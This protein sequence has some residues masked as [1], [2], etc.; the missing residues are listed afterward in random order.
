[1]YH[2][3][4]D[5]ICP[6]KSSRKHIFFEEIHISVLHYGKVKSTEIENGSHVIT[7]LTYNVTYSMCGH[8]T[9]AF[10]S[11]YT[12]YN[13]LKTIIYFTIQG[14]G[15]VLSNKINIEL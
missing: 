10:K 5:L 2:E 12:L 7:D 14:K 9:S 8:M 13:R 1:M 15:I 6:Y 3:P 11:K 4:E